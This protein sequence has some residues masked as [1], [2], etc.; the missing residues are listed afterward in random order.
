MGRLAGAFCSAAFDSTETLVFDGSCA[1]LGESTGFCGGGGLVALSDGVA[2]AA[3]L[4]VEGAEGFLLFSSRSK[5]LTK[6]NMLG[7]CGWADAPLNDAVSVGA[8]DEAILL[9]AA[10]SLPFS[11][12]AVDGVCGGR[13]M[14]LGAGGDWV[15]KSPVCTACPLPLPVRR[16]RRL[17]AASFEGAKPRLAEGDDVEDVVCW[18]WTCADED[19]G[20][21]S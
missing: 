4:G 3:A 10:A 1:T 20:G 12:G 15:W 2:R 8:A 5:G 11:L 17:S 14:G 18:D 9:A 16:A 6:S 19:D 21:C 13:E 7:V